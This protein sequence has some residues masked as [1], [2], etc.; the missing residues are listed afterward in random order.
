MPI[1]TNR[2]EILRFTEGRASAGAPGQDRELTAVRGLEHRARGVLAAVCS[3]TQ[4][5]GRSR[6]VSKRQRATPRPIAAFASA[7]PS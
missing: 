1:R 7:S 3:G 6:S 5:Y 4:L 2:T